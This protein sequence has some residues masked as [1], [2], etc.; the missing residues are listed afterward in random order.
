MD[1]NGQTP[2]ER[3]LAW[4]WPS[5]REHLPRQPARVLEIG[6]G[7]F[8]G[9]VP[10][11]RSAGYEATGV[12]PQC[13]DG[14][15]YRRIEFERHEVQHP[16]DAIVASLSLHHVGD[17]NDVLDR[18]RAAVAPGGT[19]IV[20]EWAHERFDEPTARWCFDRACPTSDDDGWLRRHCDRWHE[21]GL[22]WDAYFRAWVSEERLH[23]GHDIVREL[24]ARFD[25][26]V[27]A[28]RPYLFADL[29]GITPEEEQAAIDAGQIQPAGIHCVAR[30]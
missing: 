18:T 6:C 16:V 30:A 13:P 11:M 24:Q 27:I 10:A 14:P 28:D 3:W 29:Q 4:A 5:V 19:V 20:L 1:N 22:D 26:R 17:L 23:A 9:F 8:G 25:T 12:D 2:D 7:P 21:S 15:D